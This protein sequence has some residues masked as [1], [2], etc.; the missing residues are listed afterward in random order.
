VS[1][2]SPL[3]AA[4]PR[5]LLG[6]AEEQRLA[7]AAA[8]GD[9]RAR[10]K[11]IESN[12][13]LVAALASQYR[14]LGLP[15]EDLVQE[16]AIGLTRASHRFDPERGA[17]FG[18]YA[19]WWIKQ[20]IMRA[21]SDQP[22][23]IRLPHYLVAQQRNVRRA[24]AGFEARTGRPPSTEEIACEAGLRPQDVR[25]ALEAA[26][27][28]ESLNGS[29]ANEEAELLDLVPDPHSPDPAEVA[30]TDD[31]H[32]RVTE[33]L[34]ELPL[35]ECQVVRR[36]FGLDGDNPETLDEIAADLGVARERVRQIEQHAL[37]TLAAHLPP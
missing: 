36:H 34:D 21:L 5:P 2:R 26:S 1:S 14:G 24:A 16:G 27:A 11:L 3:G 6:A 7:R 19:A 32:E 15:M 23:A 13:R 18:T 10:Q 25:T 31:R 30:A 12:L 37:S 17:R 22:R 35:R 33:A 29:A 8:H 4:A 9:A 28:R 20:S